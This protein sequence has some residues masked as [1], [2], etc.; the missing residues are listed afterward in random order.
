MAGSTTG[1]NFI[2]V[3]A[4]VAGLAS[5]IALKAS[6]H[7]VLVLEKEPQLGGTS[8]MPSRCARIP[9]NGSKILY[10][11]GLEAETMD[12]AVIAEGFRLYRYEGTESGRDH[13]G[14][15]LWD[16]ELLTEARGKFLNFR[17]QDLLLILYEG[18]IKPP[19]HSQ[20]TTKMK[21]NEAD[22]APRVSVLFG[23]EVVE[24]DCATCTVTLNT[25]ET[26]VGDV[27]IGADGAR[28]VVRRMLMQEEDA[29]PGRDDSP[30]GLAVYMAVI[31]K[32]LTVND[33]DLASFY[34]YPEYTTSFG[35]NRGALTFTAGKE[36]E[37]S[38]CIYTPDSPGDGEG[39]DQKLTDVLG[40]CD[41]GI[42]KLAALAKSAACIQITDPY[43]LRSWVSESGK[44]V[45]LG[46]AAHPYPP[47]SLHK[48]SIALEDGA[49]IGKIFSHTRDRN[50]IPEFL[51]AF[52]EHRESR[53]FRIRDIE[54]QYIGGTILQDGEMQAARD[55]ALRANYAAGRDV[56]DTP[57]SVPEK[58]LNET[59]M[60]F[61]YDPADDADEWWMSWGRLREAADVPT[62]KI[63]L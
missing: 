30:T 21:Q 25:G 4:S 7:N 55:A 57:G 24:V 20:N 28:G 60:V 47:G 14:M 48:Y 45:V 23:A 3:G 9:P 29:V 36:R 41:V 6:G 11:W 43:R 18:L 62:N 31:P 58:L 61:G 27:I 42:R 16:P 50:R 33:P 22:S 51:H 10:D 35:S 63:V 32:S 5:A 1:F 15:H 17:H 38:L 39:N 44:V 19:Q 13:I 52:Q 2:I 46:E 56:F 37:I 49:F 26:H 40:P 53:C 34:E 8:S 12:C 54:K 59:V